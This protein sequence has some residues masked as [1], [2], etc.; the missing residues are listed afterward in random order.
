MLP[1]ITN[2]TDYSTRETGVGIDM[3]DQAHVAVAE[4]YEEGHK[5]PA[6]LGVDV[7]DLEALVEQIEEKF[8]GC[9]I[10]DAMPYKTERKRLYVG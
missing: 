3:G 2:F 8:S 1:V 6:F 9:L 4:P 5:N 10:I 7:K